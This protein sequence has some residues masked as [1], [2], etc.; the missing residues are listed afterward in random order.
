[1]MDSLRTFMDEMLDDQG[2]KEGFI[3]DLL[4]N[5][6]TQ[7][8]PTLEQAQTG[9]TTVS[10]LHGIFYN[11]DASEVTISYKVVPDMYAP[12]T[13]SFRQFEVVLEGLLTSRR[14][15]KWQIKQDK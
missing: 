6:T 3:S 7:P 15:Q 10:N 14:N 11:Y 12:Y 8:I 4:A 1:M 13:M 2:R 9:Y 5:L